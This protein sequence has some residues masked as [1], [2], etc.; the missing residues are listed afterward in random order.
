MNESHLYTISTYSYNYILYTNRG[1][2][3][4][5][6]HILN[7]HNYNLDEIMLCC[8]SDEVGTVKSL[9]G[10]KSHIPTSPMVFLRVHNR[11]PKGKL[12]SGSTHV[13]N[14]CRTYYTVYSCPSS[15]TP[16]YTSQ[17]RIFNLSY[18]Y[19]PHIL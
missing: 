9:S 14:L 10:E 2:F 13:V 1:S 6:L 11:H 5:V 15:E 12:N 16:V 19:D 7:I 17:L 18:N 4:L 3:I 8:E